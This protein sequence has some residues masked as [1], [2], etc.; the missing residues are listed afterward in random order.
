MHF[1][2]Y[3]EHTIDAKQRL[4][5]PAKYRAQW[6]E[7]RDGTAWYGVPWPGGVLRL[8]TETL[9]NE[10][11]E[12]MGSKSLA[13]GR[14][15]A[16]LD[17]GL[18]G[19]SERLE[20]DKQG[21]VALPRLALELTGLGSEVVIVGARNRLEVYDRAGWLATMRERFERLPEIADRL[22]SGRGPEAGGPK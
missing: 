19:F 8:Y 16:S 1:T 10:L 20:M 21:R 22:A 18:F 6:D 14:D 13:P 5:I 11:A 17:A 12:M 9:F 7:K 2:G 3:S 15:E 4:A